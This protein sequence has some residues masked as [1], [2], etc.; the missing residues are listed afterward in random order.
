MPA[1]NATNPRQFNETVRYEC[2][3]GMR[4]AG[5]DGA[6]FHE[7]VVC[8][9]GNVYQV[10]DPWPQCREGNNTLHLQYV[11][12]LFLSN[13]CY[14][15]G[16]CGASPTS[17]DNGSVVVKVGG[18]WSSDE[19]VGGDGSF[20]LLRDHKGDS[21]ASDCGD[22]SIKKTGEQQPD[23]NNLVRRTFEVLTGTYTSL[24]LTTTKLG[25]FQMTIP[26]DETRGK[27]VALLTFFVPIED[28]ITFD[29]TSTVTGWLLASST[30]AI[31]F[32]L[33]TDGNE[34]RASESS[35]S[36]YLHATVDLSSFGSVAIE[37]STSHRQGD[38]ASCIREFT[39]LRCTA[40][41]TS[42]LI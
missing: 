30:N 7:D 13:F 23:G 9:A 8:T 25:L 1:G 32:R 40:S 39:C 10:P 28:P 27:V 4:L 17:P 15:G 22:V 2:D 16:Y 29:L 6:T 21:S 41:V 42:D 35:T 36:K 31:V 20:E 5:S 24:S 18:K 12:D 37:F 3:N 11:K 33:K 26:N 14:L 34:L 19:C 38:P